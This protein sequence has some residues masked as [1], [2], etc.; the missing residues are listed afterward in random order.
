MLIQTN[1]VSESY[2][3]DTT[4]NTTDGKNITAYDAN[5]N[6]AGILGDKSKVKFVGKDGENLFYEHG[7]EVWSIKISSVTGMDSIKFAALGKFDKQTGKVKPVEVPQYD[8]SIETTEIDWIKGTYTTKDANGN[9]T[10]NK[11]VELS[12]PGKEPDNVSQA[13]KGISRGWTTKIVNGITLSMLRVDIEYNGKIVKCGALYPKGYVGVAT[14]GS[15]TLTYDGLKP[16]DDS[17]FLPDGSEVAMLPTGKDQIQMNVP[18]QET[19]SPDVP[20]D[21][22]QA[23]Y[24]ASPNS[25]KDVTNLINSGGGDVVILGP[26]TLTIPNNKQITAPLK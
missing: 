17:N 12:F 20:K 21:Q 7:S 26:A 14:D 1:T 4:I 24:D 11:I 22:K 25:K 16:L 15:N 3:Y 19:G 8:S 9:I 5:G 6:E 23:L 2:K 18:W 13:Y 10:V